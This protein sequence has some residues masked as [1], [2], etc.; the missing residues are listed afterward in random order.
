MSSND[1]HSMETA[2]LKLIET[3]EH[4]VDDLINANGID[5]VT[6]TLESNL[7]LYDSLCDIFEDSI[8]E[9]YLCALPLPLI[10]HNRFVRPNDDVIMLSIPQ[11]ERGPMIVPL[12][13]ALGPLLARSN[14]DH[15]M[16]SYIS[17]VLILNYPKSVAASLIGK[18][19]LPH[20][21]EEID[22]TFSKV[23]RLVDAH[24]DS[25]VTD[26]HLN[27]AKA[28][29]P[30]AFRLFIPTGCSAADVLESVGVPHYLASH[31]DQSLRLMKAKAIANGKSD[32]LRLKDAHKTRL[33]HLTLI[34]DR[35]VCSG[36]CDDHTDRGL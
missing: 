33:P 23:V 6:T 2:D 32:H 24:A 35:D 3:L 4:I 21:T 12:P 22:A 16:L 30:K 10:P 18:Y 1:L 5:A 26:I 14:F 36:R 11:G 29:R 27:S 25:Y 13:D 17:R 20:L 31:A 7:H 15:D 9:S 34:W 28:S 19:H 8:V